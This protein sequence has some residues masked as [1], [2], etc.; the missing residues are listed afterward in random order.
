MRILVVEH[1]PEAP[2][3]TMGPVLDCRGATVTIVRR[4]HLPATPDGFD[5]LVVLGAVES[6]LGRVGG[7]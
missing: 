4:D 6:V 1:D 5:A 7:W 3:G 2:L